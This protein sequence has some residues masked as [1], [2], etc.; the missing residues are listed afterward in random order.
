MY[1]RRLCAALVVPFLGQAEVPARIDFARDVQPLFK[2]HCITCHGPEQQMA[3]LRLDRRRDAMRGGSIAVIAPGTSSGS[4]LYHK[5]T[6][7]RYGAQMPPTG[8]LQADNIEI[9]KRWLDQGAQWPDELA[10]DAPQSARDPAAERM[11][12]AL[13]VGDTSA[14]RKM[15]IGGS[16]SVNGRGRGGSTPLMYAA[17]YSDAAT[18]KALLQAGANPNL[19]N[20]AGATP[21]MW[22]IDSAEKTKLLLDAGAEVD[23][24]S[25][26]GRTALTIA[27]ARV[28]ASDG[29]KL[30]LERGAKFNAPQPSMNDSFLGDAESVKH[31]LSQQGKATG[32]AAAVR[33][34]C[35]KCLDVMLTFAKPADLT[36]PLSTAAS[37]GDAAVFRRLA[38][39]AA[40]L[41]N[42]DGD[43]FTILMRASAGEQ[44]SPE[45]VQALLDRGL[46][47]NARTKDGQTALDYA[48]RNGDTQVV[49]MLRKAGGESNSKSASLRAQPKPASS[50]RDALGRTF[51]LLRRADDGFLRQSGC[52]SCHNNSLFAMTVETAKQSGWQTLE[53]DAARHRK[54]IAPYI[55]AWRDRALQGVGI[56]GGSDTVSYLL[57]GLQAIGYVP[58]DATDALAY[59]LLGRQRPDGA[60]RVQAGRPPME[61]SDIEV[62]ATS[63][64][65]LQAYG[66]RALKPKSDR[67]VGLAKLWLEGAAAAID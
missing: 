33:M 21:L 62:T 60:W 47:V 66:Q 27:T 45:I 12:E 25:N 37:M 30:L 51:P 13:S 26:D 42:P 36:A 64:R 49:A 8:P 1:M 59:Y 9:I 32:L 61:S 2:E 19:R 53:S 63:L 40:P 52:V 58:D 31:V 17:L 5:I 35:L 28:G 57:V 46:D 29:V 55:E 44:A 65:A 11:M 50:I 34:R 14:V 43:G 54:T 10:G 38:D 7:T 56:P 20:E 4:R 22:A 39:L 6:G 16:K 3:N 18:V 67:A 15:L 23:A 24:R 41:P 48:L